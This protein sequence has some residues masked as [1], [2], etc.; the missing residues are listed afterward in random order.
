MCV[1]EGEEER[2][3]KRGRETLKLVD[4]MYEEEKKKWK[5]LSATQDARF[6]LM[7]DHY[8]NIT[9]LHFRKG[10]CSFSFISGLRIRLFRQLKELDSFEGDDDLQ[11]HRDHI[12]ITSRVFH[13][14]MCM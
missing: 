11:L 6:L 9:C 3:K 8:C 14:R 5:F 13:L 2:R 1:C 10:Y 7:R 12:T 4:K